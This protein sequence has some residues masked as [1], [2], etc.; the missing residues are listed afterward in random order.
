[1][2][3]D[4]VSFPAE[5]RAAEKKSDVT[6]LRN[7]G[8]IPAIVYSK[9]EAGTPVKLNEHDFEMMLKQHSGENMMID[10]VVDGGKARHVLLKDIQHHP[11]SQR[12]LHVD[13]H[14]IS[15]DRLVKVHVVVDFQGTPVG[16]TQGGGTLDIQTREVEVECKASA[17]VDSLPLD[18]SGLDIGN[19][20]TVA[21]LSL[22]EGYT[23]LTAE[24][25]SL[26][27]MLAPR[28]KADAGTSEGGATEGED[29][30]SEEAEA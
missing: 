18:V 21:D 3:N 10:L 2:A 24:T 22:P 8:F 25:V 15:L 7:D 29:A 17:I 12:I 19:N 6:D 23:L 13:F 26:A 5:T 30:A 11:M 20:V 4:T 9:G 27:N 14:E 16:V 1:M 28:V